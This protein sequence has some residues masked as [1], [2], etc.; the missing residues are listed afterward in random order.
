M[1]TSAMSNMETVT[2]PAQ[3]APMPPVIQAPTFIGLMANI[4]VTLPSV[5]V[6]GGALTEIMNILVFYGP[7]GSDLSVVTPWVVNGPFPPGS[8]QNIQVQVPAYSTAYD[9]EAEVSN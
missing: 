4:P 6:N 7:S 2:S 5:D 3:P 1:P 9:F 8:D